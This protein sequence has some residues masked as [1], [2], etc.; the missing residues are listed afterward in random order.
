MLV[1]FIPLSLLPGPTLAA[2]TGMFE[3]QEREAT[4]V[5][6][7]V[8]LIFEIGVSGQVSPEYEGSDEY[9]VSPFPIIGFGYLNIPG[10][11]EIGSTGPDEGGFSI[12]PSFN[13]TGER[14]AGDFDDLKGLDDVDATYEVGAKVGY[15]WGYAE[16]YGEARYAF[17]GAEGIVGELGANAIYRPT[18]TIE[19]KAGPFAT[20]ASEDFTETY[21]GVTAAEAD[22]IGLRLEAYDPKGGVKS[23][24]VSGSA[25]YEFRR[26]WFLNADASYSQFVGDAKDSPIVKAGDKNQF[27][28]GF[29][30][31]K[32]FEMDLFD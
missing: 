1:A 6:S 19:L 22:R 11:F 21:F 27:T 2:D 5:A 28:V 31:S 13:M 15:E 24:G 32:R 14:K 8:D 26:D 3:A 25:R 20:L 30:I 4:A 17:G 16:I 9:S 7:G 12:N 18:K 29:G 23:V 10:L